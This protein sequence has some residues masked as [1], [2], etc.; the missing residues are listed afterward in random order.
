MAVV[1]VTVWAFVIQCN[2]LGEVVLVVS[3]TDQVVIVVSGVCD[4]FGLLF[5]DV[6]DVVRETVLVAIILY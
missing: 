1:C 3:A 5:Y 2:V 6:L 4:R